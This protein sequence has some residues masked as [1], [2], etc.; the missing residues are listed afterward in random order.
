MQATMSSRLS[1]EALSSDFLKNH[2]QA[3]SK[4]LSASPPKKMY[5]PMLMTQKMNM[6]RVASA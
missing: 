4:I 6:F 1:K 2:A 3:P 5:M